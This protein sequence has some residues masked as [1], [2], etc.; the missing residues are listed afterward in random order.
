MQQGPAQSGNVQILAVNHTTAPF[1][2][3]SLTVSVDAEQEETTQGKALRHSDADAVPIGSM[4]L[5]PGQHTLSVRTSAEDGSSDHVISLAASQT[6]RIDSL[7]AAITVHVFTPRSGIG[8]DRRVEL[9]FDIRGGQMRAPLGALASAPA[10]NARCAELSQVRAAICRTELMVEKATAARDLL[11][12]MC[13]RDK[14][15]EMRTIAITA[16]PDAATN[17][18]TPATRYDSDV[19]RMA[20][21][22]VLK[23]EEE[24]S[25]CA[26]TEM[27][28]G[29]L[30]GSW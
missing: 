29:T 28:S 19:T 3:R 22:R 10:G 24:L 17:P 25:R 12:V 11:L 15:Q 6:F 16:E 5:T 26:T 9:S 4:R 8:N 1:S 2:L 23:L 21:G 7:P 13:T 14:L 18:S 27:R 30:A 20:A